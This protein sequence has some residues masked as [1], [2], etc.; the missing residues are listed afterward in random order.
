[1]ANPFLHSLPLVFDFGVDDV[2]EEPEDA[3]VE[4]WAVRIESMEELAQYETVEEE[5]AQ[6]LAGH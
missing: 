6:M 2:V 5:L 4:L 1:M 3:L